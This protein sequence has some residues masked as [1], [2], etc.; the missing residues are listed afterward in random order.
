M[1]PTFICWPVKLIIPVLVNLQMLSYLITMILFKFLTEQTEQ[2]SGRIIRRGKN[3]LLQL[4]IKFQI[5]HK[6]DLLTHAV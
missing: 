1:Q 5:Q 2:T 6:R 3:Y 4:L